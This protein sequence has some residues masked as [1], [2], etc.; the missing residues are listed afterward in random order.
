M[1]H[2]NLKIPEETPLLAVARFAAEMGCDTTMEENGN[3][4]FTKVRD[5]L[6][7]V[8]VIALQTELDFYKRKTA[9]IS[10][11]LNDLCKRLDNKDY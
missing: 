4:T 6:P 10:K 7:A 3:W 1:S 9:K 5:A 11:M 2:I 8:D